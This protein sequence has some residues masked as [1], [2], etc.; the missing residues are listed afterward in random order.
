MDFLTN[1]AQS[2]KLTLLLIL[3]IVSAPGWIA[4]IRDLLRTRGSQETKRLENEGKPLDAAIILAR[5]IDARTELERENSKAWQTTINAALAENRATHELM[6]RTQDNAEIRTKQL[7]KLIT[8]VKDQRETVTVEMEAIQ[9]Q[10]K[11][12]E[13]TKALLNK[14]A[15]DLDK[16]PESMRER[17]KA[18][19]EDIRRRL[20]QLEKAVIALD[21]H[22]VKALDAVSAPPQVNQ[23]QP[24]TEIIV[25]KVGVET[26]TMKPVAPL[27]GNIQ[28][29]TAAAET[30]KGAP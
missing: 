3:L 6:D 4:L 5:S 20:D 13:E 10:G 18:E 15:A 8:E 14:I 16:L 17:L 11:Q 28:A 9:G 26:D 7:E 30:P 21:V 22:V 27:F 2:D 19:L 25:P 12:L 24:P 1:L 23:T 29:V